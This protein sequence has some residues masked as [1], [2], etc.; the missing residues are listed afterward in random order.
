M[1]LPVT[2]HERKTESHLYHGVP[3]KVEQ[4]RTGKLDPVPHEGSV[5]AH[6]SVAPLRTSTRSTLGEEN[7]ADAIRHRHPTDH[8]QRK[9]QKTSEKVSGKAREKVRPAQ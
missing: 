7:V 8:C 9:V 4:E 6:Y 5:S 1:N 2:Y 3:R